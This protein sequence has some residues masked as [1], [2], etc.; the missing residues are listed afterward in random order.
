MIRLAI[1]TLLLGAIHA[2][3]ISEEEMRVPAYVIRGIAFVETRSYWDVEGQL[4]YVDRRDGKAGERGPF[5]LTRAAFTQVSA[6][7]D[8]F[9]KVRTDPAYALTLTIR[10]LQWL[11]RHCQSWEEACACYNT[12]LRGS[13]RAGNRYYTLVALAA[14]ITP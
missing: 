10:Y 7:H 5:Q 13:V 3:E 6:R 1:L 12:G 2:Q 11:R 9:E 8:S 4:R 14:G